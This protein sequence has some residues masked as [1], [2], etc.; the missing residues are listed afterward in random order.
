VSAVTPAGRT[1]LPRPPEV[2]DAFFAP[3][4]AR[5]AGVGARSAADAERFRELGV[6]AERIELTGDVKYDL[7]PPATP[8]EETRRR[9]GLPDGRPVLVAGSTGPGEEPAVLDAWTVAR[10]T[11]PDLVLVLAPRHLERADDVAREIS[12]RGLEFVRASEARP[13]TRADAVLLLD[14]LGELAAAYRLA[15]IAFVG[16]SL[17]PVGG[18]N[19]LEPASV[20]VPVLFGP[21]VDSVADAAARLERARGARRVRD[22]AELAREIVSLLEDEPARR[23]MARSARGVVDAERGALARS[24]A[25]ILRAVDTGRARTA[26]GVV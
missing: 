24:V 5:L 20:G 13:E 19:L 15:T 21:H 9:L 7:A 3:L 14:T 16:G 1:S 17:V 25:L 4:V 18:H 6:P 11:H 10:A 23:E 12:R 8:V 22:V 26:E 2:D